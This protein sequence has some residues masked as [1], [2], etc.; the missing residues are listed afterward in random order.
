MEES[1]EMMIFYIVNN[2]T[3]QNLLSNDYNVEEI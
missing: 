2:V 1:N 3:T